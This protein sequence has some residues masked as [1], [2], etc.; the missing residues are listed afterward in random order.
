MNEQ[1]KSSGIK[2]AIINAINI[3]EQVIKITPKNVLPLCNTDSVLFLTM[4]KHVPPLGLPNALG[5]AARQPRPRPSQSGGTGRQAHHVYCRPAAVA[6]D[7]HVASPQRKRWE[8]LRVATRPGEAIVPV[9][10]EE[11][12]G[13]A[14]VPVKTEETPSEAAVPVKS[15]ETLDDGP[16]EK[17]PEHCDMLPR[18]PD[19]LLLG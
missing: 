6:P 7:G 16:G 18:T 15:V 19:E 14:A 12:P 1:K 9:K 3:H 13:K 5:L 11:T 10:S 8:T 17:C 4:D 2:I